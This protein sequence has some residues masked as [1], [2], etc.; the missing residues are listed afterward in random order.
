MEI[1]RKFNMENSQSPPAPSNYSSMRLCSTNQRQVRISPRP[2]ILQGSALKDLHP[3]NPPFASNL[4][5]SAS[6]LRSPGAQPAP[7]P[8]PPGVHL[9]NARPSLSL[10][11]HNPGSHRP[12]DGSPPLWDVARD[13]S[14]TTPHQRGTV[15]RPPGFYHTSCPCRIRRRDK[16]KRGARRVP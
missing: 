3:W 9:S 6:S 16:S 13:P 2:I 11:Q 12:P 1:K 10:A 8:L 14:Q 5:T 15:Q 4:A 7:R